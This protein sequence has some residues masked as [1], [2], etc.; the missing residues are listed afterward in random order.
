M[1]SL[2]SE[3]DFNAPFLYASASPKLKLS[4]SGCPLMIVIFFINFS[5]FIFLGIVTMPANG[6][7]LPEGRDF[8]HKT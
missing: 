8:H 7:Q 6:L 1:I 3:P 2:T 4:L 5:L